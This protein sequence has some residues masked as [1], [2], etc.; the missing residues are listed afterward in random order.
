MTRDQTTKLL[1]E[2]RRQHGNST[3]D[4]VDTS[5]SFTS[6]AIQSGVRFDKIRDVSNMYT[7][8]VSAIFIEANGECIV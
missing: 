2:G 4:E 6:I 1:A 3:L 8:V 7:N 5:G